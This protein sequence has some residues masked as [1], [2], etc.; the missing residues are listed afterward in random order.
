MTEHKYTE[1][2]YK[3]FEALEAQR[4]Y[5]EKAKNLAALLAELDEHR[6]F[7]AILINELRKDI[8]EEIS[9]LN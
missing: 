6:A 4:V 1:A 5:D 2:K 7:N 9:G 8:A 3:Y